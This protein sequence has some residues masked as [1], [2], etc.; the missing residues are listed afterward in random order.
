VRTHVALLRAVN[1]AGRNKV[2]MADLRQIAGSLGR[3]DVAT[4]IQSGNVVF[5]T[6]ETDTAQLAGALERE[7]ARCPGV[8]PGVVVLSRH[9]LAAVIAGNRRSP[10]VRTDGQFPA[11]D[12]VARTCAAPQG[13][14]RQRQ[15]QKRMDVPVI[16]GGSG[17]R[18]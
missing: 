9:E 11:A 1:L 10:A 13:S 3:T 7:I 16:G 18:G 15:Q 5:T 14:H 2:A 8:Q 17:L 6:T 12:Q 4:Y